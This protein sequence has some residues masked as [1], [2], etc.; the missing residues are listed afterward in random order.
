M[1]DPQIP[2]GPLEWPLSTGKPLAE[3][4]THIREWG[5]FQGAMKSTFKGYFAF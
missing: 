1:L 2:E 3:N 4:M 5:Y